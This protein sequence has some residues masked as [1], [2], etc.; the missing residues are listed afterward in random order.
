MNGTVRPNASIG[1]KIATTFGG[2]SVMPSTDVF[3]CMC[4]FYAMDQKVRCLT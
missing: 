4:L 3:V 2:A 1:A